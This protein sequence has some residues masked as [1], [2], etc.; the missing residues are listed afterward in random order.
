MPSASIRATKPKRP[1]KS[2]KWIYAAA[3]R[4]VI[5]LGTADETSNTAMEFY[6]RTTSLWANKQ[7]PDQ[8]IPITDGECAAV[9]GLTRRS[10]W[11]RSWVYQEAST[12][13]VYREF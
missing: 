1:R 10:Y 2:P 11:S 12:P 6:V 8:T 4:I 9:E 3:S 7:L 5:W 13:G